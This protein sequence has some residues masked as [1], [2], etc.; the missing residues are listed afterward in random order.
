[1][2]LSLIDNSA[3]ANR[4]APLMIYGRWLPA[5]LQVPGTR[6]QVH[7][8]A[9]DRMAMKR[10]RQMPV[11]EWAEKYRVIPNGA[12]L[13]GPWRN[14]TTPYVA[15]V[16][17]ASMFPSV[18]QVILCWP[19][20]C[21][22]TDGVNTI[23]GYL[24]DRR[25]GN[26]L[27]VFPDELTARDSNRDQIT[28]MFK[29]SA[30]L[31]KY[32]TGY[33]DDAASLCLR[34]R[35]IKIFMAWATSASRLASKPLPYVVMDEE[36]KY[37][38]TPNS[39]ESSP[40]DLAKKRTRTF[41]HMRKV[42]RM[43]TPTVETGAIWKALTEDAEVIFDYWVRCP[44]CGGIQQMVFEQIK[45]PETTRDPREVESRK[46]AWYECKSCGDKWDDA[47]RN[48]A[49]QHGEWRDREK[50]LSINA[51]LNSIRPTSIG[52]HLRAY[53]SR[54][55]SLSESAAAF[56]WGLKD[57]TK[58]KD[59]KNA[60]EAEPWV[61]YT[62]ERKEDAILAL[63][64]D[65]PSGVVPDQNIVAL[66]AG[67]DSQ[68]VGYWYEIRAWTSGPER[69]S[70][71]VR[72]GFVMT[73]DALTKVLFEDEYR[74]ASGT[75]Y[76]VNL[77]VMDAMGD[78]TAEV[79]D[80]CLKFRGRVV[81][82]QGKRT[83]SQPYRFSKQEYYPGTD[84]LIPGGLM[85]VLGNTTFY[86]N[87]LASKL[88]ITRGDPGAWYLNS[89]TTNE[90]AVQ[91]TAEYQDPD[92]YWQ[93]K[94]NRANHAWDCSVYNLIAADIIGVRFMGQVPEEKESSDADKRH[95]IS[96]SKQRW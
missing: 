15:G 92:G 96:T 56:L 51:I 28:P 70:W 41:A 18:Q 83:L 94:P 57:K 76:I 80:Y 66:T 91:M 1:M 67:V 65:R 45:W 87:L 63:K 38:A 73:D 93:C 60:H 43:S 29:D 19:P 2:Q 23:I 7:F 62:Y 78:R 71:Q 5:H 4:P 53:V 13:P 35:H 27:Y 36:D 31:R 34:M 26:V 47:R 89:E 30:Q 16:M 61:N 75:R 55:V 69:E 20:Q 37:P 68:K 33:L 44:A 72:S 84:K 21:G 74:D 17:D 64:D 32:F 82:Y 12:A 24:T 81:P 49:V 22:K 14:S 42:F 10:K 90:W 3:A 79:Y 50:G 54:F 58:L 39:K 6:L 11:S 40:A 86:K 8:T 48:T 46:L 95:R 59:F 25:P 85:L 88:D 52:F 77:V 9:A